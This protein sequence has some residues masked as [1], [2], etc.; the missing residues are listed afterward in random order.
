MCRVLRLLVLADAEHNDLRTILGLNNIVVIHCPAAAPDVQHSIGLGIRVASATVVTSLHPDW[1]TALAPVAGRIATL[2][3]ELGQD[4]AV[5][6]PAHQVL[7]AFQQPF[8]DVRVLIVGQDPYP[9][10]GH[11][12]G[13]AFATNPDVRP[14]PRSLTNIFTELHDDVGVLPPGHGDLSQ[15]SEQGVLLLN[16]VLTVTPG[17]AGSH[18]G[19]GW[20]E[21]TE[22]AIRALV[23]RGTPLVSVLWGKQAQSLTPLLEQTPIVASPHPSPL[24]ARRGFFGSRPFS[25]TNEALTAQGSSAIDWT[26]RPL[27][28]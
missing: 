11:A 18:R 21:V 22:C 15:W 23:A 12:I 4:D 3:N 1:A 9:T 27:L 16:R 26:I 2:T 19:R 8:N 17:A 25:R 7:R 10:P 6:P 14:L 5:L 13:L 24:S 20:E 28:G